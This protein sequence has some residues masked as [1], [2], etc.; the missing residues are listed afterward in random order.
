MQFLGEYTLHTY[1]QLRQTGSAR[2]V[3]ML[4]FQEAGRVESQLLF[5]SVTVFAILAVARAA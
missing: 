2:N 3:L 1:L 4:P 5:C